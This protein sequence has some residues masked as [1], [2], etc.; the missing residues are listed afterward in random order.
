MTIGWHTLLPPDQ[1]FRAQAMLCDLLESLPT[2]ERKEWGASLGGGHAGT[3]LLYSYAALAEGESKR[4]TYEA[5]ARAHLETAVGMLAH[6]EQRPGLFAG[7]AGV[8]WTVDHLQRCGILGEAEDLNEEIDEAL[9]ALLDPG[10]WDGLPELIDG[11]A[12]IGLYAL[13]RSV[14]ARSRMM[15]DQILSILQSTAEQAPGGTA[16]FDSAAQLPPI[17]RERHPEGAFNLGVAHGNPGVIGFLAEAWHGGFQQARPLLDSSMAWLLSCKAPHA[18]GSVFGRA[19]G[20]GEPPNAE[21]SR[22]SWCYGDLGIAAVMLV[23]AARTGEPQWQAE[24]IQLALSCASRPDPWL[25]SNDAC[26]C[27]G[28]SGNA[29]LFARLYQGTGIPCFKARA[30]QCYER[31]LATTRNGCPEVPGLLEGAV[32]IG[33]S[34]LAATTDV[35]P[36]WDRFLLVHVPPGSGYRALG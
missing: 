17:P 33:L 3:A 19:F 1:A 8:A 11:L 32:G 20:R 7:F 14:C 16:W 36:S 30:L 6:Y 4:K 5:R 27:H 29:H 34:L 31:T 35:E 26:L 10:R 15:V 18:D 28:S 24:G 25:G 22:L 13:D 21:G 9:L 23:V 12:G 2:P